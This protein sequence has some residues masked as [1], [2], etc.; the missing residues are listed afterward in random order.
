MDTIALKSGACAKAVVGFLK[1]ILYV[2]LL[3]EQ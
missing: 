1:A 2:A 3:N